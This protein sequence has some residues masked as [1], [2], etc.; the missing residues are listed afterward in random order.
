MIINN[1]SL[2]EVT[3]HLS[4]AA[5]I[6][7]QGKKTQN[8]YFKFE[9]ADRALLAIDMSPFLAAVLLPCMKT[10]ESITIEGSISEKLLK[11]TEKIMNLVSGW[12]IDLKPIKIHAETIIKDTYKPDGVGCFF[13]AG[14]DS[15]YTY[16]KHQSGKEKIT[17]LILVHGFDI[18][19]SNKSFFAQVKATVEEVAKKEKVKAVILETNIGEIVEQRL[20]WD[21]SHGGA[22]GAVA[23]LLRQGL[24]QVYIAGAV[25]D[26]QLFPYG[27]HPHLDKLW[28]TET[29]TIQSDGGE[30]DRIEKI[31]EVISKSSLA[32]KYLR[33]CA[34][35]IKGK[36]NCSHC[37]KCLITMIYLTGAD[38][39]KK[40]ATFD[41]VLDPELVKKMYYDYR[42]KY[43]IQGEMAL[44]LLIKLNKYPKIQEAIVYS[45]EKSKKP[46]VAKRIS[47]SIAQWD[48]RYNDR[49]LYRWVFKINNSEDRNMIFKFLL[50]KGLLK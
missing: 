48:Q 23:L 3:A 1:F 37:Y 10:G 36:Y 43:N 2:T 34:Q 39:L 33:V 38:A 12:N 22:L 27:T 7:F 46:K 41:N 40:A 19:L 13:T 21:F 9:K 26:D 28:S 29:L 20:V 45:L 24:K 32:L 17:H 5:D 44:A 6:T 4:I 47:G 49:R 8:A 31:T 14:V 15:F 50:N 18:P 30:H 42:L 25:K 35:N 11:N 16:L